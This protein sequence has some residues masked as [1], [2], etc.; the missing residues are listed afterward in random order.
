M[1]Q[2][3]VSRALSFALA[4]VLTAGLLGGVDHLVQPDD[5]ASGGAWAQLQQPRG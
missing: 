2:R 1:L 4:A 5:A 3:L